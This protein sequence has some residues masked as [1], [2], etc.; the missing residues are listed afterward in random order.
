MPDVTQKPI[1][2]YDL[3]AKGDGPERHDGHS[4]ALALSLVLGALFVN[5]VR[6]I[7]RFALS[8]G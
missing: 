4:V 5:N 2:F 8:V 6:L 7:M 1:G 3:G